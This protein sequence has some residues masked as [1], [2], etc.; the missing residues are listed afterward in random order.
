MKCS[1][2]KAINFARKDKVEDL[3]GRCYGDFAAAMAR[4]GLYHSVGRKRFRHVAAKILK[5]ADPAAPQPRI[6]VVVGAGASAAAAG[7]P[8]GSE[9]ADCLRD[10]AAELGLGELVKAEIERLKMQFNLDKEDFETT[11][12]ALSKYGREDVLDKLHLI[13]GRRHHPWL[14]YELLAHCLKHRFID[15]VINFNFDEILDQ[16][17]ED[18]VGAGAFHKLVLDGDCPAKVDD[19][20][21]DARR[22]FKL[23]LYIKPHG[24]AGQASSMRFTRE[25][26]AALSEGFVQVLLKLFSPEQPVHVLVLGYAMQSIEFNHILRRVAQGRSRRNEIRFFFHLKRDQ[27]AQD[28]CVGMEGPGLRRP[29]FPG[30]NLRI[31]DVMDRIWALAS[32]QF[33]AAKPRGIER[34]RLVS[35]LFAE[36]R[37]IED[38][39]AS[40]RPG[41]REE[42]ARRLRRYFRDRTLVEIALAVAK[43]KGF[44]NVENLADTRIGTYFRLYREECLH[45]PESE[46]LLSVGDACR[47]LGLTVCNYGS[48][49]LGN[50]NRVLALRKFNAEASRL[51][52]RTLDLVLRGARPSLQIRQRFGAALLSMYKGDEV[53]VSAAGEPRS[54]VLFEKAEFLPTLA[55]LKLRTEEIMTDRSL[56][57]DA[58]ACTAETG[59]WLCESK[60][61]LG[62]VKRRK[63]RLAL[64]VADNAY[65]RELKTQ[66]GSHLLKPIRKLLWW[67]HNRHVTVFLERGRPRYAFSF[68]RRSRT[69]HIV[70]FYLT[71]D[72]DVRVIWDAFVAYWLKAGRGDQ[73]EREISQ[74]EIDRAGDELLKQLTPP[75]SP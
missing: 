54:A 2:I 30:G 48:V 47:R 13:F 49:T 15:A 26:Y 7:L 72:D 73:P 71:A 11:L 39:R 74:R 58:L 38:W 41:F 27:Y 63:A 59:Q 46:P 75:A 19:W 40:I 31:D 6:V 32:R 16:A 14:G 45:V 64:V 4:N 5:D 21:D 20:I 62:E 43:A 65:Q 18:E 1:E 51:V 44:A 33:R 28:V 69:A 60:Y 35:E 42:R 61:V 8:C 70:P 12:L 29:H 53:E 66:F 24:S 22:S 50:T 34:H 67:R 10:S 57:W 3:A 36:P 56:K 9:A 23:P 25:S 37:R 55:A 68:E 52:D 17:I